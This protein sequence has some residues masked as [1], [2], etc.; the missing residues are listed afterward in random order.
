VA[1]PHG[2]AGRRPHLVE[3]EPIQRHLERAVGVL[4]LWPS[5]KRRKLLVLDA[6]RDA[7]RAAAVSVGTP[8]ALSSKPRCR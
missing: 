1:A 7:R 2:H 4:T 8:T 5:A 6:A 3:I